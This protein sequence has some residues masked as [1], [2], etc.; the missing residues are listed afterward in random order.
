MA[1]THSN[2]FSGVNTS[3]HLVS[4]SGGNS[5]GKPCRTKEAEPQMTIC[6]LFKCYASAAGAQSGAH[7]LPVAEWQEQRCLLLLRLL[8]S[9][10][11]TKIHQHPVCLLIF[12]D[13]VGSSYSWW[14]V[15][16]WK[17]WIRER[18]HLLFSGI[19]LVNLRISAQIWKERRKTKLR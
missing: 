16:R 19:S 6:K 3:S 11:T 1:L 17:R 4:E 10:E 8:P 2:F 13:S 15:D 5:V 7:L 18:F 12:I 14:V 9:P